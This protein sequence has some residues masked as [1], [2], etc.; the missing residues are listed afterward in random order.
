MKISNEINKAVSKSI[1]RLE[2]EVSLVASVEHIIMY[3][4]VVTYKISL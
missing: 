1:S 2:I 4:L 3:L